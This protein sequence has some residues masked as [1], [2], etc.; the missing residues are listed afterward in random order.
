MTG[1]EP[2]MD[3]NTFRVFDHVLM[4]PSPKLHL[5]VTSNFSADEKL[6]QRYKGYVKMLCEGEKI[7]HF[8]QYVSLD[9]WLDKA[10]YMRHGLDFGLLWNRVNEF[11]SEIP[12]RS[13]L[14]F[15]VTMNNLSVTSFEQLMVAILGLRQ[16]YSN[17]YQRVWFDTPVLRTPSWQSMQLLPESYVEKLEAVWVWM[18]KNMES[19]EKRFKGFKDYELQRLDRD[20]AW[21]RDGQK[22][23]PAYIKRQKADFYRFFAEHDRRRGTDFLKTFP[24]MSAWWT[25][26]Q[27]HAN[28]D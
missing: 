13:S 23:D 17:T 12:S 14:T 21:M 7:E 9:G 20:I 19:E 27:Y 3:K 2:M 16:I 26:C 6:W 28:N 22:L 25:E 11:L 24:E 5:N 1:G 4:N 18:M 8:M 15:I 10:E